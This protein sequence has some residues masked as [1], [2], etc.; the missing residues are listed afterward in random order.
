VVYLKMDGE[1]VRSLRAS[2]SAASTAACA[3]ERLR[4]QTRDEIIAPRFVEC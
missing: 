2:T 3:A 1:R 4:Q